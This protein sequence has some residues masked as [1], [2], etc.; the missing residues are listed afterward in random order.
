MKEI[1]PDLPVIIMTAFSDL[2]SAVSSF[3]GGAFEYLTKPFDVA[4]AV[5]LISRAMEDARHRAEAAPEEEEKPEEPQPA[6]PDAGGLPRHRAAFA[7]Q[8]HSA[9]YGRIRR[10]QGSRRARDLEAQQAKPRA[11]HCHQHGG[12]PEGAS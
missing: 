11:L 3:Q 12:N 9:P 7:E 8:R 5:E 4:K 10:R 2:D 6:V 1:A